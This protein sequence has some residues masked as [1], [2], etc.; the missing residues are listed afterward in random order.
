M[1]SAAYRAFLFTLIC[2]ELIY[3]CH[4]INPSQWCTLVSMWMSWGRIR[5]WLA[6]ILALTKRQQN[7][8]CSPSSM[9]ST[10]LPHFIHRQTNKAIKQFMAV[11]SLTTVWLLYSHL[12]SEYFLHWLTHHNVAS[13]K[14]RCILFWVLTFLTCVFGT[15]VAL[16][17]HLNIPIC[18]WLIWTWTV[19]SSI[20]FYWPLLHIKILFFLTKSF[21][22]VTIKVKVKSISAAQ[23]GQR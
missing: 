23:Y 7:C 21:M 11:W 14:E 1:L 9:L 6:L 5:M 3:S 15:F 17:C 12:D 22:R 10:K 18:K 2:S 4:L 8:P 16:R 13:Y 20:I 19:Y